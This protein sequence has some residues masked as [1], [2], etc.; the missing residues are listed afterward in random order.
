MTQIRFWKG[1][2]GKGNAREFDN[3]ALITLGT[4]LGFA[5][6]QNGIVQQNELGGPGIP[7]FG[8]PYS[9][10]ILEDYTTKRGIVRTYLDL[11]GKNSAGGITVSE[12]GK[13]ADNGDASSCKT[14]QMVGRILA[15][16]LK[17]IIDANHIQC[18]LLGGQI[19]RSFH[20][21]GTITEE[22]IGQGFFK[23]NRQ[24]PE[25]I[26][27]IRAYTEWNTSKSYP[28]MNKIACRGER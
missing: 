4:G 9:E 12:I 27:L 23:L 21:H 8:I 19:S 2:S 14:F 28:S 6:S 7:I 15:E 17:H 11:S 16:S 25:G 24:Q 20:L 26:Y 5:I 18:L 13:R 1:R 10:G 3:V 22:G